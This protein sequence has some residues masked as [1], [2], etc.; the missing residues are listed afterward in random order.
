MGR[1]PSSAQ[2]ARGWRRESTRVHS[3]VDRFDADG[4]GIFAPESTNPPTPLPP[5]KTLHPPPWQDR[6]QAAA[7]LF[8]KDRHVAHSHARHP[9]SGRVE[10]LLGAMERADPQANAGESTVPLPTMTSPAHAKLGPSLRAGAFSPQ[11][12]ARPREIYTG[13]KRNLRGEPD[14]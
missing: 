7:G 14:I 2:P 5:R 4:I 10:H 3:S 13:G 11:I 8:E 6:A 9:A 1:T 12:E